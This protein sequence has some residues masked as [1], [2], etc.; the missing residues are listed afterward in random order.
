M[1]D[2]FRRRL[3][4]AEQQAEQQAEQRVLAVELAADRQIAELER[5]RAARERALIDRG[6]RGLRI[7][8]LLREVARRPLDDA[9]LLAFAEAVA[10]PRWR[11]ALLAA[12]ELAEVLR[13]EVVTRR[14]RELECK[15][16]WLMRQV[17]NGDE[18]PVEVLLGKHGRVL[19]RWR[20]AADGVAMRAADF[21]AHG[22]L[23]LELRPIFHVALL[24]A[25]EHLAALARDPL[26]ARLRSLDLDGSGIDDA[27]LQRLV[28]SPHVRELRWLGLSRCR[29]S[30]A[31][32]DALAASEHLPHLRWIE[33]R[34]NPCDNPCPHLVY[35]EN[36]DWGPAPRHVE[37][38]EFGREL[39]ARHG[40]K[41][42]IC[43][44]P[45][46]LHDDELHSPLPPH[47][48]YW[49]DGGGAE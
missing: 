13:S 49:L 1:I 46:T 28:D 9:P 34:Y 3:R 6:V 32:I 20:G 44:P 31:G 47:W 16:E 30:N 10:E 41:R 29:I 17:G 15:I 39:T 40:R 14:R 19:S 12:V 11:E 2:W 24:D 4:E 21:L 5:L 22:D 35:E 7:E 48:Y 27:G 36:H 8:S 33:V 43:E 38:P 18:R 25:G 26:L 23:L 42:W 45:R 37:F